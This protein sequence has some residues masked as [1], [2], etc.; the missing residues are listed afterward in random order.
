[1]AVADAIQAIRRRIDDA[2]RAAGRD[3]GEIELIPVSK[4]HSVDAIRAAVDAGCRLFGENRLQE[5]EA[6]HEALPDVRFAMIGPVQSNKVRI[7][8]DAVD[9]LHSLDSLDLAARLDRRLHDAGRRLPVLI[10]VNTSDEPQKSGI[11]PDEA[12]RFAR[13]MREFQALQVQGLMTMAMAS[14]DEDAVRG[15]F[16]RLREL[17][18]ELR[19]EV[20]EHGWDELS[21]GMS[22]DFE[23]AIAEGATMVRVGTAIFGPREA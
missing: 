9:E 8:V 1:M 15:C 3:P 13:E 12:V 20:P 6:K 17:R 22:G 2:A 19:E 16:R 10:Q 5:L 11:H 4:F 18:D 23:L 7:V 14:D 21:M